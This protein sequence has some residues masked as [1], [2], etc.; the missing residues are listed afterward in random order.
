MA[1]LLLKEHYIEKKPEGFLSKSA[2]MEQIEPIELEKATAGVPELK[3]IAQN[4]DAFVSTEDEKE[5][6]VPDQQFRLIHA[7]FKEIR[8]EPLLTSKGEVE[9]SV[10]IKKYSKRAKEIKAALD[11]FSNGRT[12]IS[13][14]LEQ[15]GNGK[16]ISKHV[17]GLKTLM[18]AYSEKAQELKNRFVKANLRLVVSI[19]RRY[20]GR[21]LPLADLIQEGNMGLMKAVEKFDHTKGC[22]F[23]TYAV[24]WILQAILRALMGQTR[25]IKVPVYLLEQSIKVR[26][27]N[28]KFHE[29]GVKSIPEEIAENSGIPIGV[30]KRILETR[31]DIAYL[32]SPILKGSK[33]TLLELM[34][35][36]ES[37]VSDAVMAKEAL[38]QIMTEALTLLTPREQKIVRMRFGIGYET[39]Y[40]L[41]GV[42]KCFSLSRE[43]IRQIE[44]GAFKKLARSRLRGALRSFLE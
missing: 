10:K 39:E 21:G 11:G 16:A 44:E 28:S 20:T 6:L 42:G 29:I 2:N 4:E 30:V 3:D 5:Q 25:T 19:A 24:R 35:D 15:N 33:T 38:A 37:P 26:R 40:T 17:E 34:P 41:D 12:W 14:S 9:I 43:R 22:K 7:Y 31:D 1:Y 23:S 8:T 27:I 36:E 32:D 13:E 18:N